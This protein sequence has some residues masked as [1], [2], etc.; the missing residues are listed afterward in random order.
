MAKFKK[1]I[2]ITIEGE[3]FDDSLDHIEI[4]KSLKF[5]WKHWWENNPTWIYGTPINQ[6]QA[7]RIDKIYLDEMEINNENFRD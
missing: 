4:F 3:L 2:T 5:S 6:M 7:G 1:E